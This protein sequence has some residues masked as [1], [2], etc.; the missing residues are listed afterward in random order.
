MGYIYKITNTINNK[1]YIGVTSE[2]VA[3]TRWKGHIRAINRGKGCPALGAAIKKYG[4]SVF[5]FTILIIC[6]DDDIYKFEPEYIKKYDTIAPNG[7]NISAGGRGSKGFT[8]KT[9]TAEAKAIIGKKSAERFADPKERKA[10]S[11]RAKA[12][13][14]SAKISEGMHSS[15]KWRT[16]VKEKR[17]GAKPKTAQTTESTTK[18]SKSLKE[19]YAA[20]THVACKSV[21]QY[22]K[23]KLVGTYVSITVAA[24]ETN[25]PRTNIRRCL[26]DPSKQAGGYH[27]KYATT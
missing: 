3:Q 19:Y 9:H 12:S 17:V 8:G 5:R 24:N 4:I 6:F 18:I 22:E 26:A 2:M 13:S 27:W 25:I 14:D 23:G 7:Y 10:L 20:H 11:E 21:A 1:S 15:E 16:A